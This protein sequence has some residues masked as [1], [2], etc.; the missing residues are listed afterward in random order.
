[1]SPLARWQAAALAGG[2]LSAALTLSAARSVETRSARAFAARTAVT[3]AGYLALVTPAAKGRSG[4]DLPQLPIRARALATLPA[5]TPEVEVYHGT[6][7][8]LRGTAKPLA[9]ADVDT[10]LAHHEFIL[11]SDRNRRLEYS[12]PRYNNVHRD[13]AAENVRALASFASF[14]PPAVAGGDGGPFADLCRNV[15]R[16]RYEETLGLVAPVGRR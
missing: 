8:L 4:Y 3:V 12:S 5:W 10:L 6:A 7:P 2:V 13:F 11:N 14:P 16:S 9:P 1:M 15:A